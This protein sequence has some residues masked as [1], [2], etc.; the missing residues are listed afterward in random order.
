MT[1]C[2]HCHGTGHAP[3]NGDNLST[4]DDTE[5]RT[6]PQPP[7]H[8]SA[9]TTSPLVTTGADR[10][11]TWVEI[12]DRMGITREHVSAAAARM[13]LLEASH[14]VTHSEG[15]LAD[16]RAET[17]AP[18]TESAKYLVDPGG[19]PI[20][21]LGCPVVVDDRAPR[22]GIWL[23]VSPPTGAAGTLTREV[24]ERAW[25]KVRDGHLT[26]RP[27]SVILTL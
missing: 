14:P 19:R 20:T 18:T 25:A 24:L 4:P 9:R 12:R 17:E 5:T 21:L 3:H 8:P 26:P 7:P 22:D 6:T 11:G 13:I 16:P 1:L 27:R 2:P 10:R 15:G 23:L